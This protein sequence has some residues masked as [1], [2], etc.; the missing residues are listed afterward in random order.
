MPEISLIIPIY[1]VEKYLPRC[2]DS[3]LAQTYTDFEAI[4]VD[5]GST[6][7]SGRIC[8]EY[9]AKDHRFKVTHKPNSGVSAARNTGLEAAEGNYIVFMDSDDELEADYLKNLMVDDFDWVIT[10][11][12]N[13]DADETIQ[14]E[15]V[16]GDE[17]YR[18][19]NSSDLALMMKRKCFSGPCCKRFKTDI[20]VMNKIRF[21][22]DISLGED[23]L[24][25]AEYAVYCNS[26]AY[27][28]GSPYRYYKYSDHSTLTGYSSD[29]PYRMMR[30]HEKIRSVLSK[31][32]EDGW[33]EEYQ[34]QIW[35]V[36]RYNLF[37]NLIRNDSIGMIRKYREL[38]KFIC[39][40]ELTMYL[41]RIDYFMPQ[42]SK[43]VRTVISTRSAFIILM[44][45][46]AVSIVKK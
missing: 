17:K 44:F 37:G 15:F 18:H 3:V 21:H 26:I 9:A 11:I 41:K 35:N 23:T 10:G 39:S 12:K 5:D 13:L 22:E 6:D 34:K 42:D 4:L 45:F 8:D 32:M 1:K 27:S 14:H 33:Q 43:L 7:G 46:K 38:R 30:V 20:I 16:Y 40:P 28:M 24:F 29:W 25:L 36:Y 31:G 2:L 19:F